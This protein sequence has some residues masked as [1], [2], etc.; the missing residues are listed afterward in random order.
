MDIRLQL[1]LGTIQ[2]NF[3]GHLDTICEA[4]DSIAQTQAI[5]A[6]SEIQEVLD[7][8]EIS[9]FDVVER[10]VCIFEKYKLDTGSRHDFG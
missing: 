6:L 8:D 5:Q 1:L 7:R 9:D 4:A 2:N 3:L 10:I